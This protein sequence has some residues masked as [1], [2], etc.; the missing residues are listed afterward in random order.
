MKHLP[1]TVAALG[2]LLTTA[3]MAAPERRG[4]PKEAIEACASINQGDSCRFKGRQGETL[5]GVCESKR[6]DKLIC[7]PENLPPRD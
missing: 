7:A 2:L 4:P 5:T 3:A 1:L 6:D